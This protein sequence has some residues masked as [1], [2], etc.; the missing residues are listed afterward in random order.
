MAD[1]NK[2][3]HILL[4]NEQLEFLKRISARERKPVGELVREAL[5]LVYH[6]RSDI[7]SRLSLKRLRKMNI[8]RENSWAEIKSKFRA[9]D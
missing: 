6:P 2:R 5:E 3:I 8:I 9:I 4:K 1:L 7:R